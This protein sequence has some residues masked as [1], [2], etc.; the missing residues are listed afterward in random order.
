M[1]KAILFDLGGV[2]F[3]RGLSLFVNYIAKKHGKDQNVL[4]ES[5]KNSDL[6]NGYYEGKILRD[7]FYITL[8]EQLQID[9][10]IKELEQKLFDVYQVIEEVKQIV[11]QLRGKYKVY[12]LS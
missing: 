3:T 10:N 5:I 11:K 4:Y 12:F 9:D 1:I 6:I 8:K 7:D 2:V